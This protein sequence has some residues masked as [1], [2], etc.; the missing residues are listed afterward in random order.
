M[1]IGLVCPY[2]IFRGGGVQE[3]VLAQAAELRRR[4][5]TVKIIT[6]RPR[7]VQGEPPRNT[8]FI[9]SSAKVRTPIKTSLELGMNFMPDAVDDMLESERFDL[10]HIH[11]PEVPILGAQ[12]VAKA[13]CPI[14]ATFHA[15]YPETPMARTIERFRIP[16]SKSIFTKLNAMS[17]VS[18]VA[19]AFVKDRT[20]QEVAIIPNGI[21]LKKY[22]PTQ[23]SR[24]KKK[25]EILF[26]GRLE[27]RKGARYLLEAYNVLREQY[28]NV[29]LVLAGDGPERERL[30][31]MV[32]NYEIPDVRFLGFVDE[33]EKLKLLQRADLFCSPA[34][35]GE[36]FGIVLLEAMACGAVTVAGDNPGYTS[37]L[38]DRGKWSLVNPKDIPE[39]ARR[40]DVMLFDEDMRRMWRE[41][42]AEYVKR[43][44]YEEI[45]DQYEKLYAKIISEVQNVPAG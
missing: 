21:D 43:F 37:V 3:H 45:V 1:K 10:L 30:E 36:S 26:I 18:E 24:S 12:I 17:A 16:Y 14:I 2:D 20:K 4:G 6:P 22:H 31:M 27:K 11:E 29:S 44:G 32:D 23:S 34:L 41:W 38:A 28:D 15:V 33:K 5:H 39:F 42:A 9:G 13:T 8:I 40:L 35:Y 19:A 25:K 7:K